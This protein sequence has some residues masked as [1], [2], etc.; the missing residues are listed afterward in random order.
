MT[1]N[2]GAACWSPDASAICFVTNIS[3]RNN[4]WLLRVNQASSLTSPVG[5]PVQLT[6]ST[7]RQTSPAWSPDGKWIA[8][9][10]DHNGDEQWDV[11][12]VSPETGEVINLT[13]TPAISEEAPAWSPDSR[14]V[15]YQ[16]KPQDSSTFE[17]HV[18]DIATRA[19]RKIT[20]GTPLDL[21]NF[22]PRW[23]PG[24]KFIAY[25]QVNAA[26]K[27]SNIFVAE[28]S[29]GEHRNLTP[30]G[31][32]GTFDL[33]DWSPD[34]KFIL[35]TS[36][37][38]NQHE[39][40]ALIEVA[41]GA[42][43][44]LTEDRWENSA[45]CFSP[46]MN[47]EAQFVTWSSN[48]DGESD[49]FLCTLATR[50]VERLSLASGWN[51]LAG[52]MSF[53]P[54]GARLLHYHNG[55]GHPNDLWS[56][57]LESRSSRQ[58]TNSLV[59]GVA[60]SDMVEPALVHFPSRDGKYEISSFVYVPHNLKRDASHPA[61]VY[62][63]GGPQSQSV[64]SFNR[65]VQYLVNQGYVVIAPNYRG[66]TGYGKDFQDANRFDMGGGDLEDVLAA[67][68]FIC[69]TGYVDRRKSVIMGGSYGGY[70]T[71]LAVAK[72]PE[73][74]AAGVAIVPFVNW[75][76]ELE[77]EDPLLREYDLATMGPPVENRALYE[78]RSPI[79]FIHQVKAPVLLLAG[80]HDPRC[81][82]EEAQ[83]VAQ[84]ITARGG[85]A[86]LKI[87]EDEGHGFSKVENMIDAYKRV[88]EFLAQYV[89]S[90]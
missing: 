58:L 34:G 4:L 29:T 61:I 7:E 48:Q 77:N 31:G 27:D 17:I 56:Y 38:L 80:A 50:R 25:T 18:M 14:S 3:G 21:G 63:H 90:P 53:A 15:A 64:N 54:D 46:A 2:V 69:A 81:P 59:A 76:T 13:N 75:F 37:G 60:P 89:P 9:I 44:W 65:A 43:E 49:I 55:A 47:G 84:A 26:G 78:D 86:E 51:V 33:A 40:V 70:M 11:F 85:V 35:C 23:S 83:Q 22:G 62:V 10:S 1:R 68:D 71:M 41:S 6:I 87:Y 57:D 8:F 72:A 74:W 12:M 52:D 45:G 73:V 5:W 67:A 66:S 82:A 16:V 42:I 20:R 24:G 39:N 32:E 36:N 79:N 28:L 30:H 88:A 19:V